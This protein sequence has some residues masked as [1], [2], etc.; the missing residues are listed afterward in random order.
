[1]VT[2]RDKREI[3]KKN[4]RR[5]KRSQKAVAEIF[6]GKDIGILGGVD[7]ITDKFSIEVKSRKKFVGEGWF[8]QL[9]SNMK[10]DSLAEGKT[11]IVI[12]HITHKRHKNDYVMMKVEDFLNLIKKGGVK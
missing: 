3:A 10:G 5:G 8:R 4:R 2:K 7:V 11:P 1:M 6:K 9:I 12:V